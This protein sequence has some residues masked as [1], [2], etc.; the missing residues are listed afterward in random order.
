MYY[1]VNLSI[2]NTLVGNNHD[3]HL[4]FINDSLNENK[5]PAKNYYFS[6]SS[7][8]FTHAL[9]YSYSEDPNFMYCAEDMTEVSI[10][11]WWLAS[12]NSVCCRRRDCLL[13]GR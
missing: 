5:I 3:Q 8:D 10:V 6:E 7:N 11:N 1:I 2:A 13:C 9:G 12:C 4:T